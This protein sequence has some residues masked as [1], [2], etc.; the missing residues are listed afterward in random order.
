MDFVVGVTG[1]EAQTTQDPRVHIPGRKG[2]GLADGPPGSGRRPAN[3]TEFILVLIS[4][5]SCTISSLHP[6]FKSRIYAGQLSF[7]KSPSPT[8]RPLRFTTNSHIQSLM[9]LYPAASSVLMRPVGDDPGWP[10]RSL[11]NIHT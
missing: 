1:K 9:T 8:I 2:P 10:H 3:H 6:G 5:D 4:P 11:P 7:K